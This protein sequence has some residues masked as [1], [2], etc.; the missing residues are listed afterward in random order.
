MKLWPNHNP[1]VLRQVAALFFVEAT[2]S[3]NSGNRK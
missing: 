3:Q 1:N 2:T